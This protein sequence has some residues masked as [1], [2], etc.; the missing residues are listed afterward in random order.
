[1]T[2]IKTLLTASSPILSD[3]QLVTGDCHISFVEGTILH[4]TRFCMASVGVPSGPI[5]TSR[6]STR[7]TPG[8][9]RRQ[10]LVVKQSAF[11]HSACRPERRLV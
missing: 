2:R 5:A 10:N 8:K 9:G 3:H 1:M 7:S 4:G 6:Y 11:R